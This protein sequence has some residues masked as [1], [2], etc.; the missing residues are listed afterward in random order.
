[1]LNEHGLILCGRSMPDTSVVADEPRAPN[2]YICSRCYRISAGL[3]P[4]PAFIA[5]EPS[6]LVMLEERL[7]AIEAVLAG[8][9][10]DTERERQP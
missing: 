5:P 10:G 8:R 9:A 1:M 7:A 4:A 3:D 6:P 2:S